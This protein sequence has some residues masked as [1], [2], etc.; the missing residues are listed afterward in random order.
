M[1]HAEVGGLNICGQNRQWTTSY[2]YLTSHPSYSLLLLLTAP[3]PAA[4]LGATTNHGDNTFY[5]R[6]M[7]IVGLT[8]LALMALAR[9]LA[10]YVFRFGRRL[11]DDQ[12]AEKGMSQRKLSWEIAWK[13]VLMLMVY[14]IV[15]IPL[16]WMFWQQHRTIA[17]LPAVTVDDTQYA[18]PGPPVTA[19]KERM[20]PTAVTAA[21][22]APAGPLGPA[23]TAVRV[24]PAGCLGNQAAPASP[25]PAV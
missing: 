13:P 18:T 12:A 2:D 23:Q 25:G 4:M 9:V 10:W 21:T 1:V 22:P 16:G 14:A 5:W 8:I 19:V 7:G 6:V 15:C 20:G 17:A 11:V 24:V 3:I